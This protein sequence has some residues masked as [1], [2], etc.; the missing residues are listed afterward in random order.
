MQNKSSLEAYIENSVNRN[1]LPKSKTDK[2]VD[3]KQNSNKIK[4]YLLNS[5]GAGSN[6][7][8]RSK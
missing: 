8:A 6:I 2:T 3:R 4:S 5:I 1:V 7:F